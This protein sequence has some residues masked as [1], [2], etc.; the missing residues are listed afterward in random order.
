MNI[1][2]KK[3]FYPSDTARLNNENTHMTFTGY[4]AVLDKNLIIS[5]L[6]CAFHKRKAL[7]EALKQIV[8]NPILFSILGY[9]TNQTW[10]GKFVCPL[11]HCKKPVTTMAISPT[12]TWVGKASSRNVHVVITN[13]LYNKWQN[14][15][16]EYRYLTKKMMH[17]KVRCNMQQFAFIKIERLVDSPK[18]I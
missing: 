7:S 3:I 1:K 4:T 5:S 14:E 18:A 11:A 15:T 8:L 9:T 12:T 10:W 6:S 16:V 17:V 13:N 2:S